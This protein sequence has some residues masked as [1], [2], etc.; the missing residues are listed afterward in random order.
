LPRAPKQNHRRGAV[1]RKISALGVDH[2]REIDLRNKILDEGRA[3]LSLHEAVGRD[4]PHVTGAFATAGEMEKT[5]RERHG[6]A[7]LSAGA[8]VRFTDLLPVRG[9][10]V[11]D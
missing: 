9:V 2:V 1:S 7:E 10:L 3:E 8:V 6:Q 11:S 4:H 5:L